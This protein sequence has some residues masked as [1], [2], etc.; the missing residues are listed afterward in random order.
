MDKNEGKAKCRLSYLADAKDS[1]AIF[2]EKIHN[3]KATQERI[4]ARIGKPFVPSV[5][6]EN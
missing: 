4:I 2:F 5:E 1:I 3:N 6:Y